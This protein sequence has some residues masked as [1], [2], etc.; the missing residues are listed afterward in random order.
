MRFAGHQLRV[1]W[2]LFG[3]R[4]PVAA[5]VRL[6]VAEAAGNICPDASPRS[7][8]PADTSL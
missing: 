3:G 6:G 5:E 2:T 8:R 1:T 7:L 4:E